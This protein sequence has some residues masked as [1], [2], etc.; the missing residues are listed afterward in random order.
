MNYENLKPRALAKVWHDAGGKFKGSELDQ[1]V[2]TAFDRAEGN[3]KRA[4]PKYYIFSTLAA[5][6][7]VLGIATAIGGSL[8]PSN[9][10]SALSCCTLLHALNRRGLKRDVN[11]LEPAYN[12]I[13]YECIKR[14]A[15]QRRE[16]VRQRAQEPLPSEEAFA[17]FTIHLR[18]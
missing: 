7:I 17:A 18:F 10:L 15:E 12:V 2:V 3:L 9:A 14:G 4:S 16:A 6:S 5:M 13:A 1:A 11:A 8:K